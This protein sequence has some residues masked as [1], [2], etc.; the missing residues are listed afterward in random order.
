ME[1]HGRRAAVSVS[2]LA[3]RSA[4]ANLSESEALQEAGNLAGLED[5]YVTHATRP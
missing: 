5:R 1:R 2:V 4:L 3:M